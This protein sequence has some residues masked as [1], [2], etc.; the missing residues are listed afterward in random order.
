[1][2]KHI[3]KVLLV[4][5]ITVVILFVAVL[6]RPAKTGPENAPGE[7]A[8]SSR[9]AEL[10]GAGGVEGYARA[11]QPRAFR[12][13]EDH[14]PHPE[15]RN[16]WWYV[17]GNLDG[18]AAERFGFELTIFRFSLTPRNEVANE[19]AS[20]W[21]TNQVFIGHFAVSDVGAEQFHVAQRYSRGGA[22]LAGAQATPFHVWLEDWSIKSVANQD[23]R[24]A[25]NNSSW[26]L[27]ASDADILLDLNLT[28]TKGIVLNGLEGLSQKSAQPG[29]ASYYYSIPRLETNGRLRIGAR[30]YEVAGLAWLDR[31]WGSSALSKDQQGWDWF[32]LQLSDGTDLMFYNLRRRDGTADEHSAGTW[33]DAAGRATHLHHDEVDIEVLDYWESEQGD[34]YPAEWT[35]SVPKLQLRIDVVP[36]L[37]NQELMTTVR[38]WEGAV[39]VQG[40]SGTEVV[41]GRGYVELTGYAGN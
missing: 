11:L 29:N 27:H 40:I 32:A 39:D 12:F 19:N 37:R 28:P 25:E 34:R 7:P 6:V 18:P 36:V 17:T 5:V 41:S 15:F 16:E 1:V 26:Q 35:I 21:K 20:A 31:E 33:I 30:T 2:N 24:A 13:P 22:G 23:G 38:Y 3:N 14:G 4:T 10:L 9:L 8:G